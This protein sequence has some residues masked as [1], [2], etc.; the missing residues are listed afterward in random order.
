MRMMSI[1]DL[2]KEKILNATEPSSR[3]SRAPR[4]C[5]VLLNNNAPFWLEPYTGP[6]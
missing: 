1:G 6:K 5:D 3:K 2:G 4:A